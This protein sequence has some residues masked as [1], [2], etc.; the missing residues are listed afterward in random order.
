[1]KKIFLSVLVGILAGGAL[2]ALDEKALI[3][4]FKLDNNFND[5]SPNKRALQPLSQGQSFSNDK[6]QDF[7]FGPNTDKTLKLG[8]VSKDIPSDT[9]SGITFSGY[10]K[11]QGGHSYGGAL[12]AFESQE[13]KNLALGVHISYGFLTFTA[14]KKTYRDSERRFADADGEWHHVAM[15]IPPESSGGE[16][17][18]YFDGKKIL[19]GTVERFPSYGEFHLAAIGPAS[20]SDEQHLSFQMDDVK[21]FKRAL[22]EE[23]IKSLAE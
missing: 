4:N 8:A 13:E 16:F 10:V 22:S 3:V 14:G 15:V 21:I 9:S 20:G 17:S 2:V 12:F 1:M 5:S 18:A 11:K 6:N 7:H 23:E 19:S